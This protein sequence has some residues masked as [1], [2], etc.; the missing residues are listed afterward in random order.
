MKKFLLIGIVFLSL[1]SCKK[2]RIETMK[3][4]GAWI[5]NSHKT[6]TLI[7]AP[8]ISF[9]YLNRGNEL[10][11][12]YLLPKYL[13]GP[14]LYKTNGDSINLTWSASSVGVGTNYDF[15]LDSRDSLIKIQ[16]FFVD[17]LSNHDILIFSKIP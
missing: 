11:N 10:R 1:I 14:Y 2:D 16:N 8:E 4:D 12:G 15:N 3:L 6:D 17:T 5:E 9:V 7:F 13:S